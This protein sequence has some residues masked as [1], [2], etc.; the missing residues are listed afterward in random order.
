M[1]S[2]WRGS[3]AGPLV[4]RDRIDDRLAKLGAVAIAGEVE[5]LAPTHPQ[6]GHQAPAGGVLDD[7]ERVDHLGAK[8][9]EAGLQRGGC[10]LPGVAPA[11][12]FLAHAPARFERAGERTAGCIGALE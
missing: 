1:G 2:V 9:L 11:P 3:S 5:I 8:A 7:R 6:A 10:G 4:A 12:G